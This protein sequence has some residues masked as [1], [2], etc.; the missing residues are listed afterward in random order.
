MILQ[1]GL[2]AFAYSKITLNTFD[3]VFESSWNEAGCQGPPQ[4]IKMY[5]NS[6]STQLEDY[7]GSEL[8]PP[9]C[10]F[11]PLSIETGC[12]VNSLEIEKSG[13]GSASYVLIDAF[14]EKYISIQ[15]KDSFYCVLEGKDADSIN[16]YSL[17]YV[18]ASGKCIEGMI[19]T[20]TQVLY[21]FEDESCTMGN[22]SFVLSSEKI[23]IETVQTLLINAYFNQITEP[24]VVFTWN[25]FVPIEH[26]SPNYTSILEALCLVLYILAILLSLFVITQN[27]LIHIYTEKN[28]RLEILGQ[29]MWFLW[30]IL[31]FLYWVISFDSYIVWIGINEVQG[32]IY[33]IMSLFCI[34]STMKVYFEFVKV[35]NADK[36]KLYYIGL[37]ACHVILGGGNY[38]NALKYV[39]ETAVFVLIWQYLVPIYYLCQFAVDLFPQIYILNSLVKEQSRNTGDSQTTVRLKIKELQPNLYSLFYLQAFVNMIYVLVCICLFYCQVLL[40]D[41][42]WLA[43]TSTLAFSNIVHEILNLIIAEHLSDL[44]IKLRGLS[45]LSLGKQI[46]DRIRKTVSGAIPTIRSRTRSIKPVDSSASDIGR[47]GSLN[48]SKSMSLSDNESRKSYSGRVYPIDDDEDILPRERRPSQF[49]TPTAIPLLHE[50]KKKQQND[51]SIAE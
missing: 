35:K 30:M 16:G 50:P 4:T 36:R 2:S 46:R 24:N 5:P 19:C 33:N 41:Y 18:E 42:N 29:T 25:T 51:E 21:I 12:C 45:E 1:I 13:F 22:S 17:Q 27:I 23:Q 34:K 43:F 31:N 14:S 39:P 10:G 8:S 49:L 32:V 26:L 3:F 40:N 15:S 44:M 7:F 28:Y 9:I 20:E 47:S 38:F 6:I 11:N 37:I 48:T